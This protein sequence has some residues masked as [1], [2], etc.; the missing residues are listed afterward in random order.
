MGNNTLNNILDNFFKQVD[1]NFQI[2]YI[3]REYDKVEK[4]YIYDSF[5]C[6]MP[7]ELKNSLIKDYRESIDKYKNIVINDF[8]V[9]GSEADCI[10]KLDT[11]NVDTMSKFIKLTNNIHSKKASEIDVDIN[12]IWGYA[13]VFKNNKEEKMTLFRK[14]SISKSINENRKLSFL[15]GNIEEVNKEIF[16]LDLKVDAIEIDGITYI[17]SKYYF[18]LFFSFKEEY[19]KYVNESLEGL[20]NENVIENFDE[21]S[22]RCLDSGNLVRKLVYVVKNDRLKWL[23][24]NIKSAKEV[25]DEYGL[26]VKV[27]ENKINYSNK[28]CNISDVMK[29]ICGCCV[30]DAVDMRK[31]FATSVKA[32]S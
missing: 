18:E 32:V 17:I 1:T 11:K 21:F 16:S 6:N 8:D 26:K 22:L 14:Y 4:D 23:K 5:Y 3:T 10:E 29:L 9:I 27:E 25:V 28:Q 13:I 12:K 31:Y 19:V 15:N 30:K 20:R 2:Y 7:N 24:N